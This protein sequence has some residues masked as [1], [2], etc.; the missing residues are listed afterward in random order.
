MAANYTRT[1]REQEER[2][3]MSIFGLWR[4]SH[5]RRHLKMG[6]FRRELSLLMPYRSDFKI[7]VKPR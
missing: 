1:N 3:I 4:F 5:L 6:L 7:P 2:E